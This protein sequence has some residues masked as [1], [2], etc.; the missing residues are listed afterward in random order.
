MLI[1]ISNVNCDKEVSKNEV[2]KLVGE[3]VSDPTL[4]QLGLITIEY[5][6][7]EDGK[8]TLSIDFINNDLPSESIKGIYKVEDSQIIMSADEKQVVA[9][10]SFKDETLII[11]EGN[12]KKFE[13]KH[14]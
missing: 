4:S 1:S 10:Y 3:W 14:K 9:I 6:F 2:S 11:D 5:S 8:Y 7:K 12:G 13:L